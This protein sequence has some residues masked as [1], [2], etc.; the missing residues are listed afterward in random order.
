ML[1]ASLRTLF[2]TAPFI[3]ASTCVMGFISLVKSL[4]DKTGDKQLA[5]ARSWAKSLVFAMRIR[6]TIEGLENIDPN[7]NYI[8]VC[9]HLSYADTPVILSSIPVNFR[10]MAKKELFNIPF[11]GTHLRTAAHIPIDSANPREGIRSLSGGAKLIQERKMSVL[12]FPEGGR[13]EGKLEAFREGAAYLAI[14]S[15][16]AVI[17][18]ALIGTREVLP[19]H[20]KVCR[21]GPV[22][23]RI[24]EPISTEGMVI[25]DR[26]A[27]NDTARERVAGL[28]RAREKTYTQR[29]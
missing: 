29:L 10:F 26:G 22:T 3:I 16:T 11:L 21:G 15:G 1:F 27:L 18:M 4:W 25:R 5:V 19:M 8:F 2:F 6:V 9:N 28:L 12:I 20:S 14:K 17:P 24:G 7:R 13:T 23:L